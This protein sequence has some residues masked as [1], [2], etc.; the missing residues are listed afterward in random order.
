MT[1]AAIPLRPAPDEGAEIAPYDAVQVAV[2]RVRLLA[3]RRWAWLESLRRDVTAQAGSLE[4]EDLIIALEH[5][6]SPDEERRWLERQSHLAQLSPEIEGLQRL[7]DEDE[8]SPLAAVSSTF[9]LTVGERDTLHLCLATAL[10]PTLG[11]LWAL[12][13]NHPD[14]NF[15][16][17]VL[18]GRL[19]GHGPGPTL[20]RSGNL[21]RW[22]IV[23]VLESRPGDPSPLEVDSHIVE[24]VSGQL[25]IDPR[26]VD[27]ISVC[28]AQS[29]PGC[30]PVTALAERLRHILAEGYG[31]RALLIG[32]RNS[33]RRTLAACVTEALGARA[34][35]VD[36]SGIDDGEWPIVHLHA[37]RQALLFGS[38]LV[39]W[40]DQVERRFPAAPG[41][42]G[43]Q[44]VLGDVDLAPAP[45]P[46]VLD[47]RLE[48]PRLSLAQRGEL[49]RKLVPTTQAWPACE[50]Q[51][52]VE[53][54]LVQPGDV[55]EIARRQVTEAAA[56]RLECRRLTRSRLG[57]LGKLVDCPFAREDLILP[58]KV[59]RLLDEFLFEA[60]ERAR[61]WE[62][63]EARRLFPRGTGLVALLT[64]VS[65]TGKTMAAQIIASEL[66]LDLF[67][68][69][70]ASSVSKY[71]G[72]T[73]KNLRRIFAR[74]REMNAVLLFDEADALFAKRTDVK[75]SHDRYANADTNYLLQ[76]LEDYDGVALL[77]S[78]KRQ[79]IDS[80]FV[81]RIRYTLEFPRP[82]AAE[83]LQ[84][85]R[86]LVASL[87]GSERRDALDAALRALSETVEISGAQIKLAVLAAVFV[88]RQVEEPLA[89][90]HLLRGTQ[91]ELSKEN[92]TLGAKE[93]ER[94][95]ASGAR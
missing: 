69:D 35:A 4:R 58:S 29:P 36:T 72:E 48:M 32:P 11:K 78:N 20:S 88:A 37:Q 65:G 52:L 38:S 23:R 79:N 17:E 31:A 82:Q 5:R 61:F 49:W 90:P 43:L 77:A 28:A 57:D 74:A 39:W 62:Y 14:Q 87:A 53:R 30:W 95:E 81:R 10:D 76:L 24:F 21:L 59:N 44:F 15:V 60:R 85:W 40:G 71:I 25:H 16:T 33:G 26:V 54:Y 63:S 91:R 80:A 6:D 12:F 34:L 64:G 18:A 22:E 9:E 19:F 50:F 2:K 7:V 27:R 84:I 45:L 56:V 51:H 75:D 13:H 42:A 55:A 93:R 47:E 67:R 1:G 86:R 94:I 92:R 68:V 46:G 8:S 3:R 89:L 70:L 73:A 66:Q 41:L 83:R